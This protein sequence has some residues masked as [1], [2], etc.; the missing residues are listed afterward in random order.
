MVERHLQGTLMNDPEWIH[1]LGLFLQIF[2]GKYINIKHKKL[3]REIYYHYLKHN[4]PP[5]DAIE[6]TKNAV[7]GFK[8]LKRVVE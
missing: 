7:F 3:F 6:K 4:T 1:E 2:K 5:K 8:R